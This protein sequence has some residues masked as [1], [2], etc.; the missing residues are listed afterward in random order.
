LPSYFAGRV[1]VALRWRLEAYRDYPGTPVSRYKTQPKC[2]LFPKGSQ[3]H[4]EPR[5][6]V[7]IVTSNLLLI[8]RKMTAIGDLYRPSGLR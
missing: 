5:P 2:R 8:P 1:G 7:L 4:S 6:T 3:L